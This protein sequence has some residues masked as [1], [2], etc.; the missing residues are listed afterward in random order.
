MS[1]VWREYSECLDDAA[2]ELMKAWHDANPGGS[3][4]EAFD[5]VCMD[6]ALSRRADELFYKKRK[7]EATP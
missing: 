3:D 5:A 6:P 4:D 2:G 7:S 1:R